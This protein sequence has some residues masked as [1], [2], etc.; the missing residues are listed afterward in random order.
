MSEFN[1]DEIVQMRDE[2]LS[3][4]KIAN[5]YG[6]W[7][8]RLTEWV[9][10]QPDPPQRIFY[11]L[12]GG[13]RMPEKEEIRAMMGEG[14]DD[15][16]MAARLGINQAAMARLRLRRELPRAQTGI[17]RSPKT[18]EQLKEIEGY[19]EEGYS[20]KAISEMLHVNEQTLA[21]HF[22][23]RGFTTKQSSEVALMARKMEAL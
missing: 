5:H 10:K 9:N 19:L 23:G 21:K 17:D 15:R 14:L 16:Q 6:V 11:R 2:G 22:P 12:P 1:L 20:F 3:W 13:K 7:R 4:N 18:P 8:Q